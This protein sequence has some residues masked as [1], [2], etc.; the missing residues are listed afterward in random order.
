MRRAAGVP[1]GAI[2][3]ADGD[4]PYPDAQEL[5]MAHGLKPSNPKDAI[6]SGKIP[7]H[8]WPETATILGALGLLD[9]MLKYGRSNWRAVGIRLT[10]YTDALKRHTNKLVEGEWIDPD[11]K[12]PHV[13]H[14]LACGAIIA[15]A[16]AAG[17]LTNDAMY[18]GGYTK[19]VEEMTPHVARLKELHKDK[20]PH[21]YTIADM[22]GK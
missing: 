18:P 17:K 11:S 19:L 20:N 13:S 14:I 15:D 10:I 5:A 22:E 9:G 3:Q 16:H 4:A 7:F 1:A 2:S 6:G 21:H 8:L 12:L